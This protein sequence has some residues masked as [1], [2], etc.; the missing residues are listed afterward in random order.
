M[1]GRPYF[2]VA[3]DPRPQGSKRAPIA[4][5]VKESTKGLHRWR[6]RVALIARANGWLGAP[7]D[8]A[9]LVGLV[10]VR[11]RPRGQIY[12]EHVRPDAPAFPISK[13]DIDKLERAI[14]DALTGVCWPDDSR[15][16]AVRKVKL[17][18]AREGVHVLVHGMPHAEPGA[19]DVPEDEARARTF[20]AA[21]LE[22]WPRWESYDKS[23]AI[24]V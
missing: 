19:A 12:R 1:S 16:I 14:L 6:E 22:F 13:P 20:I 10:F 7:E 17:F 11:K 24:P 4:G 5:V 8:R 15:S 9:V 2:F 23:A 21:A 3:G 18:G